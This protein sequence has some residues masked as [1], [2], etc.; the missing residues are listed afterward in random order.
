M[1][2]RPASVKNPAVLDAQWLL[3]PQREAED[4][5]HRVVG[6]AEDFPGAALGLHRRGPEGSGRNRPGGLRL[7]Q[8]DGAQTQQHDHG[9]EGELTTAGKMK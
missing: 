9:R 7:R 1:S 8:Q 2:E 3:F 6:E 5:Q 4:S